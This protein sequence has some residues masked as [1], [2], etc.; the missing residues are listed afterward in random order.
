V[1]NADQDLLSRWKKGEI[2]A[3]AEVARRRREGTLTSEQL[4]SAKD[5][6]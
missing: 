1:S 2:N 5:L 3:V 6:K 4:A